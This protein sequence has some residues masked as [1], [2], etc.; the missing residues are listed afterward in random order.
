MAK[1]AASIAAVFA[2]HVFEQSAMK[3]RDK[4]REF[5]TPQS[6][7]ERVRA[8]RK[9]RLMTLAEVAER[10]GLTAVY[11]CDIENGKRDP[12][13]SAIERVARGLDMSVAELFGVVPRHGLEAMS[14]ARKCAK[15]DK[16]L[17]QWVLNQLREFPKLFGG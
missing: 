7:G 4:D 14:F 16:P 3:K 13:Y 12:C 8:L 10:S 1:R 15:A 2:I 9:E 5:D 17:R 6:F 11:L